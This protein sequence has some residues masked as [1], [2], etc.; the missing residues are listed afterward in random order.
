MNTPS[1]DCAEELYWKPTGSDIDIINKMVEMGF[2]DIPPMEICL[3][4][5]LGEGEFGQ[6]H[7]AQWKARHGTYQVAVKKLTKGGDRTQLLKETAIMGQFGH[8]YVV[9][10][11]GISAV[12]THQVMWMFSLC[13]NAS[14][15][16]LHIALYVED[17]NACTHVL[18][19]T[20]IH[21]HAHT[22]ILINIT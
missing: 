8:P 19:H 11:L 16:C 6:V 14:L 3:L 21:T 9:Q 4:Q 10:L 13:V 2:S 5:C 22:D 17:T 7:K 15:L 12:N 1:E 20:H 18:A